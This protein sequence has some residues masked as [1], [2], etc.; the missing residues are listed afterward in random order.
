M[1]TRHWYSENTNAKQRERA[2]PRLVTWVREKNLADMFQLNCI[3]ERSWPV[4]EATHGAH[5][6]FPSCLFRHGRGMQQ[7]TPAN[8]EV[9]VSMQGSSL[10]SPRGLLDFVCS[11]ACL[12]LDVV[13]GARRRRGA[14]LWKNTG[15]HSVTF[16]LYQQESELKLNLGEEVR[17]LAQDAQSNVFS[18][19]SFISYS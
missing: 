19:I 16:P 9:R 3:P 14:M 8:S 11:F 1:L 2:M 12:L 13:L 15:Y 4:S 5:K 7:P 17:N 6:H 18:R 10:P